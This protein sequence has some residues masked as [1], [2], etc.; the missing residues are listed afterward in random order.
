[1]WIFNFF[2]D[3]G[4]LDGIHWAH[5]IG[6]ATMG[7]LGSVAYTFMAYAAVNILY[8]MRKVRGAFETVYSLN[9][10]RA[11]GDSLN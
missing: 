6:A 3:Y 8:Y 10:D 4:F 1:M 7:M 11:L 9:C 2:E 5:C